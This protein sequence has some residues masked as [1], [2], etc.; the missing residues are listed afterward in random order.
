MYTDSSVAERLSIPIALMARRTAQRSQRS[1]R[2]GSHRARFT[3]FHAL[4]C[5]NIKRLRSTRV[6][7]ARCGNECSNASQAE[8]FRIAAGDSTNRAACT[9]ITFP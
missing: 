5:A 8:S 9:A 4:L 7:C 3:V 2:L 6:P 1:A